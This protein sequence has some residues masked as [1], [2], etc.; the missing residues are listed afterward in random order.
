MVNCTSYPSTKLIQ[1]PFTNVRRDTSW[2][3]K[4]QWQVNWLL[5]VFTSPGH[6]V[7]FH[8]ALSTANRKSKLTQDNWSSYH[9][10]LMPILH[11]HTGLLLM[12]QFRIKNTSAI[13]FIIFWHLPTFSQAGVIINWMKPNVN[14]SKNQTDSWLL[15]VP[16]GW[17]RRK[18]ILECICAKSPTAWVK[19]KLPLSWSRLVSDDA[20]IR[21]LINL[22]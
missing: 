19:F 9:A 6:L 13:D 17:G 7:P 21:K 14:L 10:L 15:E 22:Y 2:A 20:I 4:P 3:A 11:Q 18:K 5:G 1:S 12:V 8:Q 16:F